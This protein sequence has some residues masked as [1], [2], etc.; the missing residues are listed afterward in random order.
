[1]LKDLRNY[2]DLY[3]VSSPAR[4]LD[5]LLLSNFRGTGKYRRPGNEKAEVG[6]KGASEQKGRVVPKREGVIDA[7]Y[8][9]VE[10]GEKRAKPEVDVET[11]LS[12]SLEGA[13][14]SRTIRDRESVRDE[15]SQIYGSFRRHS[16]FG[17]WLALFAGVL[18]QPFFQAYQATHKWQWAGFSG[19]ALFALITS[20]LIFPAVYRKAFD[21]DKPVIVQVGPIFAAGLGWQ[22]LLTTAVKVATGG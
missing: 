4:R 16:A 10:E 17:Q 15:F 14:R 20:I 18:I 22:S 21:R 19:W 6:S 9:D 7:E 8:V 1:M 3:S 2:F 13:I 12:D 5:F 11:D